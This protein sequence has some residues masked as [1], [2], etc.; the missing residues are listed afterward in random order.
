MCE[1]GLTLVVNTNSRRMEIIDHLLTK[2][3]FHFNPILERDG[4]LVL[5]TFDRIDFRRRV[6]FI[7]FRLSAPGSLRMF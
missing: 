6:Y 4:S 5:K 1:A 2:M 3:H 7:L